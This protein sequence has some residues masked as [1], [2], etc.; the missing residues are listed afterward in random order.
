M[1]VHVGES[2][3]SRMLAELRVRLL[4]SYGTII[5]ALIVQRLALGLLTLFVIS[6]VIFFSVQLLPGDVAQAILGKA[7]P[8][9]AVAALRKELGLDLP[10][11][12]RYYNWISDFV[13]GDFGRSLANR[14]TVIELLSERIGNTIFLAAFAASIA[15]PVGL[16][17]GV[18]SAI[19]RDRLFDRLASMLS[20]VAI[21]MPEFLTAYILVAIFAV[22][23][24]WLPAVSLIEPGQDIASRLVFTALPALTLAF[25]VVAYILRMTRAAIMNVLSAGYI[26]MAELKGTRPFQIIVRHALP[27]ALSPIIN[28]VLMNVAYL[29]VG[30]VVVE[31]IFVYPGLGQ[32]LVDSVSKRDIPVVQAGGMV[33]AAAY[34]LLN[35]LAD[36]LSIVSNPRLRRPRRDV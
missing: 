24:Q 1:T 28:V 25:A 4:P 29:I 26:E 15:I 23:H 35:L 20:L 27:N 11:Y 33:F 22:Q 8:A 19:Y 36:I 17:L 21:S 10:A 14:R 12:V 30:V 32:L 5:P 6:L 2:K 9:E 13:Q 16:G 3:G 31:V 18:V 34:V 7:A